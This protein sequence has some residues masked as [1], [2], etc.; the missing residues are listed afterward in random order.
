MADA[1]Q[2]LANYGPNTVPEKQRRALWRILQQQFSD[3]MIIVLLAAALIS[4]FIGE[5][6]DTIAIL[7]IVLLDDDFTTIVRAVRAG[8]TIFDDIRGFIKH[9]MSSNS[10]E[11]WTLFLAPFMGFPVPLLPKQF[12]CALSRGSS[13]AMK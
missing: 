11:I 7:V 2:R 12:S 13:Q 5:P 9:T 10:G 1:Q 6:Q 3:F 4:G 8:R